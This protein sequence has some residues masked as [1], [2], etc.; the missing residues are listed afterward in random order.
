MFLL[1]PPAPFGSLFAAASFSLSLSFF[2]SGFAF[3]G[4]LASG[5]R[6]SDDEYGEDGEEACDRRPFAAGALGTA[7]TTRPGALGAARPLLL[8]FVRLQHGQRSG[9]LEAL[10]LSMMRRWLSVFMKA[11]CGFVALWIC[12]FELWH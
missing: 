1:P 8:R 9:G 12:G 7:N 6:A 5:G 4:G 3:V 10:S 11:N 2:T